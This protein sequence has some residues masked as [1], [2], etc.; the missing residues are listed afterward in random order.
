MRGERRQRKLKKGVSERIL[1]KPG[2]KAMGKRDGI[3]EI[4]RRKARLGNGRTPRWPLGVSMPCR[5]IVASKVEFDINLGEKLMI[6]EKVK[7]HLLLCHNRLHT[8]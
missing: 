2:R 3:K 6:N 4:P 1:K 8:R 5:T 7:C